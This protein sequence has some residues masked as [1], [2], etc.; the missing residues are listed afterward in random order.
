MIWDA[1]QLPVMDIGIVPQGDAKDAS[2]PTGSCI[3]Q[4]SSGVVH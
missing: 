3:R 4:L 1:V 2:L